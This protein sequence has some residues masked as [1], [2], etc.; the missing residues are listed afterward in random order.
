MK[1]SRFL[2]SGQAHDLVKQFGTPI[3]VYSEQRLR[4]AAETLLAFPN[5]GDGFTV[6]YAMKALPTRRILQ[7]LNAM[8]LHID[9]S[10]GY[11]AERAM[12]AGIP[13]NHI[14]LT[15]QLLPRNL[16]ELVRRGMLFNACSLRQLKTYGEL[17]SSSHWTDVSVRINPGLGSGHCERT[18]VGG[19]SSSFGIWHEYIPD[20]LGLAQ[21]LQLRITG[22]H[23]HIGSGADP[24]D[25]V[26]V[27]QISLAA[28][29]HFPDIT[30][31]SLGGGLK[32]A[33]MPG[34]DAADLQK[35]GK[36]LLPAFREFGRPL[37]LEIEPGTAVTALAG[38]IL[39][40]VTDIVDTGPDGYRF[41]KLD[42]GLP[43]NPR[44]AMYG[45][46]HP[47]T[48]IPST[49][50]HTTTTE[51]YVVVG[52]CCE[53]GDILT[54][55]PSDP[56]GIAVRRLP[57][58]E[59]GDIVE[60]GATGAYCA[61]MAPANYNSFPEAAEVLVHPDQTPELIRRRETLEEIVARE[62]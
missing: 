26:R 4:E 59:V 5:L 32:V 1:F 28:A 55:E 47:L 57:M 7:I 56:E 49:S 43:Q 9:A 8:G 52:P 53:S 61:S 35:I 11:E 42:A 40:R 27:A 21:R 45:A 20:V 33:R 46:Q 37:H 54:P 10:T 12:M 23:T 19:P 2:E 51:N 29:K 14:Q 44:P 38:V 17:C 30:R 15:S 58:A 60:V 31:F 22:V 6:R 3:H 24:K 36:A 39:A 18:N 16:F 48:L 25:W 34:E 62:V 13:V 50:R 41:L